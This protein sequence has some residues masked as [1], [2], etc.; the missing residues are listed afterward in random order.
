M[1]HG[2]QNMNRTTNEESF[3]MERADKHG[4]RYKG[5]A[6]MA[7]VFVGNALHGSGSSPPSAAAS[8]ARAPP[9]RSSRP[10]LRPSTAA[11]P[12]A[13]AINSRQHIASAQRSIRINAALLL[14]IIICCLSFA[15]CKITWG[16]GGN[17]ALILRERGLLIYLFV[18]LVDVP[19]PIHLQIRYG[20]TAAQQQD[21]LRVAV[22]CISHQCSVGNSRKGGILAGRELTSRRVSVKCFMSRTSCLEIGHGAC[23]S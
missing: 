13:V 15:Q 23:C 6:E 8:T 20:S 5:A 19:I 1:L 12:G 9:P 10:C 2:A 14:H 18:L 7:I 11:L 3:E 22:A 4:E 21:S 16:E 17:G